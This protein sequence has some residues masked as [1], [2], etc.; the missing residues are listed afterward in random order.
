[1]QSLPYVVDEAVCCLCLAAKVE[2]DGHACQSCLDQMPTG[3]ELRDDASNAWAEQA[4]A[5]RR[6]DDR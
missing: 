5:R 1:M 6:G 3:Q 2:V 4:K